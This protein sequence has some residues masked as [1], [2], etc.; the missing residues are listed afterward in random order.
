MKLS[1]VIEKEIEILQAT[2]PITAQE[3]LVLRAGIGKLLSLGKNRLILELTDSAGIA[4]EAL[5]ELAKL[6]DLARDLGGMVALA[7]VS[8]EMKL[9]IEKM[10]S[11]P[12]V[13]CFRDRN[14]A[15]LAFLKPPKAGT[16]SA[17]PHFTGTPPPPAVEVPAP[18][19]AA[20]PI[21]PAPKPAAP[22]AAVAP[23]VAAL[24]PM[25]L[26]EKEKEILRLREELRKKEEG[27][28]GALRHEL[29]TLKRDNDMIR[30]QIKKL[31]L[32]RR[33]P[34]DETSYQ[35]KI[36]VLETRVVELMGRIAAA[37]SK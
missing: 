24:P 16:G 33:N 8:P 18:V 29:A 32:E 31:V 28:L 3:A 10:S 19:A 5:Q 37:S 1:R 36:L 6:N 2:G 7:G 30:V 12:P 17:A 26:D 15:M 20:A 35:K 21:K 14:G 27:E 23:P 9:A 11:P 25:T 22:R 34:P 13:P 4:P